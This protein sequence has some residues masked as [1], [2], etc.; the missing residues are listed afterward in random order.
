MEPALYEASAHKHRCESPAM[1]VIVLY[2]HCLAEHSELLGESYRAVLLPLMFVCDH[3][4]SG[5]PSSCMQLP[6]QHSRRTHTHTHTM[7][8][9]TVGVANT[10]VGHL[11][12]G[13]AA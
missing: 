12:A 4:R 5:A 7:F 2:V 11:A 1:P 13:C 8:T 3:H 9:N 10:A 6:C